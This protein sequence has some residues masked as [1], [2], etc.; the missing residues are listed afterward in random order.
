MIDIGKLAEMDI[1]SMLTKQAI[2]YILRYCAWGDIPESM[3]DNERVI[4]MSDKSVDSIS[5]LYWQDKDDDPDSDIFFIIFSNRKVLFGRI[6]ELI[7]DEDGNYLLTL[8]EYD[9]PNGKI[10]KEVIQ[11]IRDENIF[12]SLEVDSTSVF[13]W[14]EE[15]IE[16]FINKGD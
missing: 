12:L 3:A 9:L 10:I 4:R 2:R 11:T 13:E 1:F 6:Y 8:K 7:C 15:K 14:N 5:V 16:E